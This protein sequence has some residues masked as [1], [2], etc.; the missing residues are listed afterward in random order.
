M[1]DHTASNQPVI[2]VFLPTY[3]TEPEESEKYE[4]CSST[5]LSPS[6]NPYSSRF[7]PS[8]AKALAEKVIRGE[9]NNQTYDEEDAKVW[10]VDIGNK[11]RE[12][13]ASKSRPTPYCVVSS[14]IISE[15]HSYMSAQRK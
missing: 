6:A 5:S 14:V 11:I 9:L 4:I 15:P 13:M 12:A 8:E 1:M 10:S 3:R 2:E 7:F